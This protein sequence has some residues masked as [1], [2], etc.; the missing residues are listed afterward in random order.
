MG[1]NDPSQFCAYNLSLMNQIAPNFN[2]HLLFTIDGVT[3]DNVII[4]DNVTPDSV[5]RSSPIM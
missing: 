5:I 2:E 3:T 1:E 4:T